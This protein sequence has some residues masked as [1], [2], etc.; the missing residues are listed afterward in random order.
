MN[1]EIYKEQLERITSK[2]KINC[3]PGCVMSIHVAWLWM[4][5]LFSFSFVCLHVCAYTSKFKVHCGSAFEPGASVLPYY[6][7][8][9]VCIPAVLGA[10]AVWRHNSWKCSISLPN[11]R[12]HSCA[13]SHVLVFSL[14]KDTM[15]LL[16]KP[17]HLVTGLFWDA[18]NSFARLFDVFYYSE[19][20]A[21]LTISTVFVWKKTKS[22][23]YCQKCGI[24][25]NTRQKKDQNLKLLKKM[26]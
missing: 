25:L 16:L 12:L 6:C 3:C 11:P 9:P 1:N 18:M 10:L 5:V 7:K 21:M 24:K 2:W 15:F 20:T 17:C 8:P 22:R 13:S 26:T 19:S 23:R 4:C 14:N